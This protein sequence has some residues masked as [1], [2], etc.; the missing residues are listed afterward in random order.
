MHAITTYLV[1]DFPENIEQVNICQRNVSDW[2]VSIHM[3]KMFKKTLVEWR[4]GP[5]SQED[6]LGQQFKRDQSIDIY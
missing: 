1:K 5:T 2:V 3:E 6:S 4:T